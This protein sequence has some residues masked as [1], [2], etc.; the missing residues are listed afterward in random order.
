MAT[1]WRTGSSAK[2]LTYRPAA[3]DDYM[4]ELKWILR[5]E[6]RF[7]EEIVNGEHM[8]P[9]GASGTPSIAYDADGDA[10]EFQLPLWA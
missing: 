5:K 9:G 10:Q 1:Q 3:H 2:K 7:A 8:C 6:S 4:L